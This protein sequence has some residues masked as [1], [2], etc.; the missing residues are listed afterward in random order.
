[1]RAA[2]DEGQVV[3]RAALWFAVRWVAML[4]LA[5]VATAAIVSAS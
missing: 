2:F 3:A 5:L 1:M 4:A